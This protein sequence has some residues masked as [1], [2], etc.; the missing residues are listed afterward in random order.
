MIDVIIK[1]IIGLF[2]YLV[3]PEI[4]CKKWKI[5]KGTKKFVSITC[6]ILGTAV[7]IFS[8]VDLVRSLYNITSVS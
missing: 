5:K 1:V 6:K 2:I 3:L 7:F 8:G 4:I